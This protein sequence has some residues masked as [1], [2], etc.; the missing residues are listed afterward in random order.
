MAASDSMSVQTARNL[1]RTAPSGREFEV[2]RLVSQLANQNTQA[3]NAR[4]LLLR[5]LDKVEAFAPY[6]KA[7]NSLL[8]TVGLFPYVSTD[9][10]SLPDLIAYEAHRPLDFNRGDIVFHEIQAKVYRRLMSGENVILSAP[11]SFGKSLVLDALIASNK[12]RNIAVVLPTL[13]LIDETRRRL[14]EFRDMYRVITHPSQALGERNLLIMTQE[15]ILDLPEMPELDLFMIDEFYKLDI[16]RSDVD[17][18]ILLNQALLRLSKTGANFYLAGPNIH[19]LSDSLP[20]D[21][22]ASFIATN[23]ATVASDVTLLPTPERGTEFEALSELCETLDGPTLVYCSSPNRARAAAKYLL[24]SGVGEP[25]TALRPATKWLGE[26]FHPDW[27]LCKTLAQ[28][29][30]IHHGKMPRAVAQ[31]QVGAFNDGALK[32]LI[33]T[34]TLI[35]GVN[36]SAKNVVVFD[37][38][39]NRKN[40]DFFTYSNI[41]GRSGRMM[42]HFV[43]NVYLFRAAPEENLPTVDVPLYT[44]GADTPTSLLIQLNDD[45]L[46]PTSRNRIEEF[47]NQH[48]VPLET[49]RENNGVDPQLQINLAKYVKENIRLVGADLSWRGWPTYDNLKACCKLIADFLHP[50]R[51][52]THGVVSASQ[53]TLKINMLAS[54]GGDITELINRELASP[55]ETPDPDEAVE[56]TLDFVRHWP[57]FAFPRLLM[58]TQSVVNPILVSNGFPRCDYSAYASSAKGM[59]LPKYISDVEEYGL[60]AQLAMKIVGSRGSFD[61]IDQLLQRL[62]RSRR[63][64][65]SKFESDLFHSFTKFL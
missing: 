11:T 33:C 25:V 3:S 18:G 10:L 63:T 62:A 50:I 27:L 23:F 43:G 45:E 40:L 55:Y 16:S 13:A 47:R 7:V 22:T 20:Q 9:D 35:E 58:T 46:K 49:L 8:R 30:G 52:R 56:R 48:H 61:S 37:H 51:G 21:F 34:S 54:S 24:E 29:I 31:Y 12:F 44:Q 4:E 36:T 2:L 19:A 38:K 28:G 5:I 6:G 32:F 57:G 41:K 42:R 15:R 14:S 17:R 1:I 65:L 59:F 53:L 64:D 26:N 39:L 60:P